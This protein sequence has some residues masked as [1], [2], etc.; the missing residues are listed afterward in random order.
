MQ[1]KNC[2]EV[3]LGR[4]GNEHLGQSRVFTV[5]EFVEAQAT[6]DARAL[7][8]TRIKRRSVPLLS[9]RMLTGSL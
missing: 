9:S 8:G 4:T 2:F 1:H 3:D 6:A 7:T 5:P